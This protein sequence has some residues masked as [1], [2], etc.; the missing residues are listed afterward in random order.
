MPVDSGDRL[1]ELSG[2]PIG[3]PKWFRYDTEHEVEPGDWLV[4]KSI[5]TE[6]GERWWTVLD[7]RPVQTRKPPP[8]RYRLRLF[9]QERQTPTSIDWSIPADMPRE[10][11]QVHFFERYYRP[12]SR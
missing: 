10:L 12:R 4:E 5:Q 2:K 6:C 1:G 7:V 3:D 11:G 8:M 9:I